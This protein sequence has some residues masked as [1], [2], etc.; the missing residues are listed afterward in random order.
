MGVLSKRKKPYDE[1]ALSPLQRL[2]ENIASLAYQ[3][4]VSVAR[5]QSLVNDAIEAGQ[6]CGPRLKQRKVGKNTARDWYRQETRESQWPGIYWAKIRV[7]N[8]KTKTIEWEWVAFLLPHE[9]LEALQ[10]LGSDEVLNDLDG[11][12]PKTLSHLKSCEAKAGC[13]LLAWGLW[14]DDV[15]CNYDR[16]ESI[17]TISINLPG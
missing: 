12:D 3:N 9:L 13:K 15:P 8:L 5:V 16:T 14:G 11:M 6:N 7:K 2:Q 4:V 17:F 1:A 10:Q